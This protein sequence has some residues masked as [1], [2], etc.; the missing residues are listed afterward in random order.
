MRSHNRRSFLKGVGASLGASLLFSPFYDSIA[1]AAPGKKPKRLLIFFTMGTAPSIW[2]PTSV[3]GETPTFSESTSPLAEIKE[4][5]VMVDGLPSGSPSNNHGSADG[6]TGMGYF[7]N[8]PYGLISVDQFIVEKL[9][10]AGTLASPV[11]SL[12]L[13]ADTGGGKTG[14]YKRDNLVPESSPVAAYS[15]VFTGVSPSTP[16]PNDTSAE[17]RLRRRKSIFDNLRGEISTLKGN[18]GSEQKYKLDLHLDSIRQLEERLS[19]EVVG[20]GGGGGGSCTVPATPSGDLTNNLKANLHHLDIIVGAFACGITRVAGIQWGSDQT[21][22]VALDEIGLRGEE[23]NGM[24]HTGAP[25]HSDLI[26]LEK[27]LHVQFVELIKKLKSIPEADGSGTLLDNTLVA[28]CRDMGDA[29]N[30]TQNEMKFVL[31]SGTGGYLKT[32]PGGRFIR[33]NE[34]H[35]RVLLSLCDAMGVTDYAGFGDPALQAKSPLPGLAAT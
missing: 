11:P 16:T 35:E 1:N 7:S 13:G 20:G 28:W 14:F 19:S 34:R 2:K 12:L 33:S 31:A 30:H 29:P 6:L 9:K 17:D 22:N 18:L 32:A 23:H 8:G 3:S 26:K 4:H 15:T 21:M 24:I 5:I 25:A 10:A 27:W